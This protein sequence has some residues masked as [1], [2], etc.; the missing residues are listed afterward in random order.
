MAS[1]KKQLSLSSHI[2]IESQDPRFT[3]QSTEKHQTS[4]SILD[5]TLDP[6]IDKFISS[7]P[8]KLELHNLKELNLQN[9]KATLTVLHQISNKVKEQRKIAKALLDLQ[10]GHV[11]QHTVLQ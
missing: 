6:M 3:I 7:L 4:S 2:E 9:P 11:K 1:A 10:N 5:R 8:E